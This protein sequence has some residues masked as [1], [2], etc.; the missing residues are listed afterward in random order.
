M[1]VDGGDKTMAMEM[2]LQFGIADG[3]DGNSEARERKG[4][5]EGRYG[6][7]RREEE[8]IV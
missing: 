6:E 7:H 8:K 1:V 3:V 4:R 2:K 5:G